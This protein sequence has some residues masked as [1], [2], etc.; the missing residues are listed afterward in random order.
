MHLLFASM[1]VDSLGKDPLILPKFARSLRHLLKVL[2][3]AYASASYLPRVNW[4]S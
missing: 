1:P 3:F 4:L 2:I